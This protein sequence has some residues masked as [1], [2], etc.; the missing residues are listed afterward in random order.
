MFEGCR[1]SLCAAC[2]ETL[3]LLSSDLWTPPT[4]ISGPWDRTEKTS[5]ELVLPLDFHLGSVYEISLVLR[6]MKV[7]TE[8][9]GEAVACSRHLWKHEWSSEASRWGGLSSF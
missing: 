6:D 1:L 7:S 8:S 4:H 2:L 9:K 5:S 3:I